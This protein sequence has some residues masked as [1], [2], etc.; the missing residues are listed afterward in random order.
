MH[1]NFE[2]KASSKNIDQLEEILLQ[3]HPEYK[4]L[5]HQVDTYFHVT[6][7]RLKLRQGRIENAL[8]HYHRQNI[9]GAKQS[10]VTLYQ[11]AP[12]NSLM[13][14]LEKALGILVIV[15]KKRKIY[16]IDNIK[17]HFDEVRELGSFVEVEAI[18]TDGKIGIDKLKE[19]CSHWAS[20]FGLEEK[21]FIA[22]S[23]SDLLL[24]KNSSI[25]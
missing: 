7:G 1:I 13:E 18:D 8:I 11:H 5:D 21:D 22:Q 19:Q 24:A 25:P 6:H 17:F 12:S 14:V 9:A 2:F 20:V 3:Y 23:Y 4:G 15:D 10:D 16:F